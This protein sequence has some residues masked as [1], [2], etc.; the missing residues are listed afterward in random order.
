LSPVA[1][2]ALRELEPGNNFGTA[3][4]L[5]VGV[6]GSGFPRNRGLFA[7]DLSSIPAD[8]VFSS[9]TFHLPV[10]QVG[11]NSPATVFELRRVLQ[12]WTEGTKPGLPATV[13]EAT[14]NW[15][16]HLQLPWGAVGGQ[17]G[18]DFAT[19]V[20]ATSLLAGTGTVSGFS[21]TGLIADAQYWMSN[22]VNNFGWV[23]MAQGEPAGSGKQVGSREHST[24]QPVLELR[25]R[26]FSMYDLMLIGQ[27]LRFSFD[28]DSNRTYAVEY[29]DSVNSGEWTILTNV[30]ALPADSTLHITNQPDFSPRYFRLRTP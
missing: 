29:R 12:P 18:V 25:Y 7:F 30:P 19:E 15:R 24:E 16:S 9:V 5:P 17:L 26:T 3:Q 11:P 4:N 2:T 27:A 20:S 13:G 22:R 6:G 10:V 8:A 28:V 21:S 14:W 23:L 1:D